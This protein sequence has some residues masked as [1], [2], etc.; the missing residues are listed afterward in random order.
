MLDIKTEGFLIC[1]KAREA[2][3]MGSCLAFKGLNDQKP[4]WA[5]GKKTTNTNCSYEMNS[6]VT[7][8]PFFMEKLFKFLLRLNF[9]LTW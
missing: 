4:T 8:G 9:M 3:K 2:K 1:I 5:H 7:F 6:E